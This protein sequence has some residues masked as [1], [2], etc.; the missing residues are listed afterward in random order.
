MRVYGSLMWSLGRVIRTPEV[1]RVFI[2]SFWHQ[3]LK[4]KDNAELLKAE[5]ADLI[6]DLR[7]LPRNSAVRKVNE[8]VKRAR[9]A[10][11]HAYIVNHLREQF[12]W[13]G[14]DGTQKKVLDNITEMFK[15]VQQKYGLP[16]GDFPNPHKF[17]EIISQYPIHAFPK[18]DPEMIKACE[19]V[20]SVHIPNLMRLIPS[21]GDAHHL[22]IHLPPT[23]LPPGKVMPRSPAPA[24]GPGSSSNSTTASSASA[25]TSSAA[26]PL[27][28]M[29][30]VGY[31][32]APAAESPS[33]NPFDV[34]PDREEIAL[35]WA[36]DQ[37]TQT[38]YSNKFYDM[39]LVSGKLPGSAARDIFMATG[40]TTADLRTVWRLADIDKDGALDCDE[41]VLAEYLIDRRRRNPQAPLPAELELG[42][43]PPSKRSFVKQM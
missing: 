23:A 5:E 21:T 7:S 13:F 1:L 16:T 24:G 29:Q 30:S 19:Q 32:R 28:P 39:K 38:E 36:I 9:M 40:L 12:G 27:S 43:V 3:P 11:V 41:Y 15:Q 20:L 14:K 31:S 26:P 10:I 37:K 25:S 4:N 18:L 6:A 42:L 8:L 33:N 22:P 17:R 34:D 2:G 35:P